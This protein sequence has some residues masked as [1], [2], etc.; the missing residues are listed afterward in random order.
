[1]PLCMNITNYISFIYTFFLFILAV[2]LF[3]LYAKIIDLY[4][5]R[6]KNHFLIDFKEYKHT[7]FNFYNSKKF[8]ILFIIILKIF[9]DLRQI[10][11]FDKVNFRLYLKSSD[12][13]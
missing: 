8:F 10:F 9:E 12:F 3:A 2:L 7:F 13:F 1:M 5:N 4:S 6:L 11:F